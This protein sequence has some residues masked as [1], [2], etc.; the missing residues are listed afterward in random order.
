MG[1]QHR[2]V[3]KRIRRKR[4]LDRVKARTRAERTERSK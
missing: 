4:Y 2:K 3:V 1:K